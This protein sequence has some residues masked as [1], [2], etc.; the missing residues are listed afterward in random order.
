MQDLYHR[1]ELVFFMLKFL[2]SSSHVHA[3]HLTVKV[4][5]FL[6]ILVFSFVSNN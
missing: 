3:A 1:I 4:P 6:L 2:T 5:G